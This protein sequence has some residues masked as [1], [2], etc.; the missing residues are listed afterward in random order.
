M[1]EKVFYKSKEFWVLGIAVLLVIAEFFGVDF[2]GVTEDAV[3]VY[4][5]ISPILALVL[6]LFFTKTKLTI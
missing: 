5:G 2:E 1:E 6:R 3:R 4:E